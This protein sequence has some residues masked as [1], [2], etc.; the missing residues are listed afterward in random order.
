MDVAD[1]EGSEEETDK[2]DTLCFV[3]VVGIEMNV[4]TFVVGLGVNFKLEF[5]IIVF[6]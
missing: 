3:V 2:N 5:I 6:Y 4:I 1:S